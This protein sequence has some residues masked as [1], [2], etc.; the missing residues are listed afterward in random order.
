MCTVLV[1]ASGLTVILITFGAALL[2][3]TAG[4]IV[5][6]ASFG[7]EDRAALRKL[8]R[9]PLRTVFSEDRPDDELD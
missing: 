3:M 7:K 9:H 1:L 8:L 4:G 6:H 5:I 2:A